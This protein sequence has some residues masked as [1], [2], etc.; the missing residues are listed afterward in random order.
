MF[1][2][3]LAV[4]APSASATWASEPLGTPDQFGYA[5]ADIAAARTQVAAGT[6]TQFGPVVTQTKYVYVKNEQFPTK[7]TLKTSVSL[8]GTPHVELV[9]A[10]PAVGPWAASASESIGFMTF[11]VESLPAAGVTLRDNGFVLEAREVGF[12][13]WKGESGVRIKLVRSDLAPSSSAQTSQ[14]PIDFGAPA[15]LSIYPCAGDLS[16]KLASTLGIT[17]RPTQTVT[18]PYEYSDG[19]GALLNSAVNISTPGQPFLAV[20]YS[21]DGGAA[22]SAPLEPACSADKAQTT[23]VFTGDVIGGDAQLASAGLQFVTRVAVPG[24]LAE[25]RTTGGIFVAIANPVFMPTD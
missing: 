23:L 5:V 22:H 24:L 7:V 3:A 6:G 19:T 16:A 21:L 17:F 10:S 4:F 13:Y 2:F 12:A 8:R 15:A 25:Y 11:A 9:Q 20:E 14:A 1:L 18:L